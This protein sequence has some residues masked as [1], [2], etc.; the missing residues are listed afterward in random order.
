M[1]DVNDLYLAAD[2]LITDYS[3]VF[4]DYANLDRPILFYMYDYEEYKYKM[5]DFYFDIHI[6]PG[7]VVTDQDELL[8]TILRIDAVVEKYQEKYDLFNE[9]FNPHREVCSEVYL[10][11]WVR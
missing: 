8:K 3:S 4:F 9:K 1:D 6:L 10:H 5:R 7:P 2:I 11:E